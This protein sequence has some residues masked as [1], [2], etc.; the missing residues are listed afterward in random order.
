MSI[1]LTPASVSKLICMPYS[2]DPASE[3]ALKFSS[4]CIYIGRT[5]HRSLPYFLDFNQLINPHVFAIGMTG[6][7]KSYLI[8]S[9][10]LKLGIFMNVAVLIIDFTGEYAKLSQFGNNAGEG[11][12]EVVLE[13]TH[14]GVIYV[15]LSEYGEAKKVESAKRILS[16][17]IVR[18][19]ASRAD[20]ELKFF[21]VIDEAWKLLL[22]SG[23]V[24]T[25]VREGRKYGYGVIIASQ[26]LGD[27]GAGIAS[28]I[29][30]LFVFRVNDSSSLQKL[31][32]NYALDEKKTS[33]IKDLNVGS[34]L[35]I[36]VFKREGMARFFIERVSGVEYLNRITIIAGVKMEVEVG[37]E[38]FN[39]IM[40]ELG[41]S[42]ASLAE[43]KGL[44]VGGT[45]RLPAL[46]AWLILHG[47]DRELVLY[48]FRRLGLSDD[49]LADNYANAL[50]EVVGDGRNKR[51]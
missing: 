23:L 15:D 50:V 39:Q 27:A 4:S 33:M 32:D 42:G 46:L 43:L 10:A 13:E 1:K 9:L 37:E 17:I 11:N 41:I 49:T 44:M 19:R 25:L 20:S 31:S 28:N 48:K 45:I 51:T 22:G 30:T 29:G 40:M 21:T 24:E 26:M 18:M 2:D 3:A 5:L 8:R 14:Q 36:Q 38:K 47:A 34:C 35:V 7:G 16:A 12:I 6:S